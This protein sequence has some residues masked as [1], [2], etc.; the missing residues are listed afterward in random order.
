M[1]HWELLSTEEK[2]K[3]LRALN[4]NADSETVI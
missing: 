4:A 2:V 1:W 3:Y